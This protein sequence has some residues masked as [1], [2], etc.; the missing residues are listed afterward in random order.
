VFVQPVVFRRPPVLAEPG[1]HLWGI[2][3]NYELHGKPWW[4]GLDPVAGLLAFTCLD[5][6]YYAIFVRQPNAPRAIE[7]GTLCVW[8]SSANRKA[9]WRLRAL[10][11]R[12]V[13]VPGAVTFGGIQLRPGVGIEKGG[14]LCGTHS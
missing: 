9:G 11:G 10:G 5:E 6:G 3:P 13:V 2:G 1:F 12:T 8:N 7:W 4:L 14:L